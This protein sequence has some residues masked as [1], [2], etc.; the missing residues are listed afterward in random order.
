MSEDFAKFICKYILLLGAFLGIGTGILKGCNNYCH[1]YEIKKPG[2]H[3]VSR[4]TGLAEHEHY[5]RQDGKIE[6]I[7][8]FPELRLKADRSYQNF[9]GDDKVDRIKI[10]SFMKKDVLEEILVRETDYA[11]HKEEFDK[12]DQLL[13]E[14]RALAD[15]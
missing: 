8:Y 12:A 7:S 10:Y 1:N 2:V 5:I 14:Y 11:E 15:K 3:V 13:L 4:A 9:D 6:E